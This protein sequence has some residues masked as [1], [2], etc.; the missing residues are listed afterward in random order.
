MW[1][2]GSCPLI[3]ALC[4]ICGLQ[5]DLGDRALTSSDHMADATFF[6]DGLVNVAENLLS[7]DGKRI[8]ITEADATGQCRRWTFAELR[9]EVEAVGGWLRELSVGPGDAVA[10]VL[11][12]RREALVSFLASSAIG[13]TWTTCSPEYSTD[14]ILDRIGQVAPKVHCSFVAITY[15]TAAVSTTVSPPISW[16][17]PSRPSRRSSASIAFVSF[18]KLHR[19]SRCRPFTMRRL[20]RLAL[21]LSGGGFRSTAPRW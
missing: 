9:S 21:G 17:L 2:Y 15:T 16:S 10:A 18:P 7:A 12:N 20:R 13:A 14:A 4:T 8:A 3:L 11:P 6:Q 5:G 19:C 1:A